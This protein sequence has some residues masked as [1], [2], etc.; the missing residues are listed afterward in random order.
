VNL[1]LPP[2]IR[3]LWSPSARRHWVG[4]FVAFHLLA[5]TLGSLP[6]LVDERGLNEEMFQDPV[7]QAEFENW[8]ETLTDLGVEVTSEEFGD[9]MWSTASNILHTQRSLQAP[10]EFY[11][12][13]AGARQRWRMFP[14]AVEEPTRL[15]IDLRLGD[16]EGEW[17]TVYLMG[18]RDPEQRWLAKWFDRDRF[19]A[20]LNLYAWDVYPEAYAEFVIWLAEQARRDFPEATQL[21][22]GFEVL[23]ALTPEQAREG[24]IRQPLP[25][26]Q[27][28]QLQVIEL[29]EKGEAT[30]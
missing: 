23:P 16:S 19:R 17:R 6:V 18:S 2:A 25:M 3:A 26:D 15:R 7:V 8:A 14:G 21:R 30:P 29:R 27:T 13:E 9:F 10:F 5:I 12:E 1:S 22:V 11:Y 4:A 20:A 24:Q 28:K